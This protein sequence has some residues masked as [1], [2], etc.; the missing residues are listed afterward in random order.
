MFNTSLRKLKVSD[1]EPYVSNNN[2]RP[3]TANYY[4]DGPMV[5]GVDRT[6]DLVGNTTA[7]NFFAQ[8]DLIV[9]GIDAIEPGQ[10]TNIITL[11]GQIRAARAAL[12]LPR[13]MFAQ[14]VESGVWLHRQM[15]AIY[16]SGTT[17]IMWPDYGYHGVS[18]YNLGAS[19]NIAIRNSP[20]N[21]NGNY[22]VSGIG[23][24]RGTVANT[25]A[26]TGLTAAVPGDFA[27]VTG[28]NI[29]VLIDTPY[30]TAGNWVDSSRPQGESFAVTKFPA[31]TQTNEGVT[32]NSGFGTK[33]RA[34]NT[35]ERFFKFWEQVAEIDAYTTSATAGGKSIRRNQYLDHSP[36]SHAVRPHKTHPTSG[37]TL[38][39]ALGKVCREQLCHGEFYNAGHLDA[40]FFDDFEVGLRA[41]YSVE[42]LTTTG[43]D[44][45]G[46]G[47]NV[48]VTNA[49][50][51]QLWGEGIR[52][53]VQDF[54]SYFPG[55]KTLCNTANSY[56]LYG[57]LHE[58]NISMPRCKGVPDML[59]LEG[60]NFTTY[61]HGVGPSN[62]Y[63][64]AQWTKWNPTMAKLNDYRSSS[65][66]PAWTHVSTQVNVVTTAD[67]TPDRR[68]PTVKN[69]QQHETNKF[70]IVQSL[71]LGSRADQIGVHWWEGGNRTFLSGDVRIVIDEMKVILGE[72]I[73][74]PQ[75]TPRGSPHD[76]WIFYREFTNAVA[77]LNCHPGGREHAVTPTV[78]NNAT[79]LAL[80]VP[81]GFQNAGVTI[82]GSDNVWS[83]KRTDT[84]TWWTNYYGWENTGISSSYAIADFGNQVARPTANAFRRITS[85][86]G[87]GVN[88]GATIGAGGITL[89]PMRAVILLRI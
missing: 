81:P 4:Y 75:S 42:D 36:Y 44:F 56:T 71:M 7:I 3:R 46:T 10:I 83:V 82:H 84:G 51:N 35:G 2:F 54:V 20:G 1:L 58:R 22:T 18:S 8:H 65:S 31:T 27:R 45:L 19:A 14:Y 88:N 9:W 16:R 77:I 41:D 15:R 76:P 64:A 62:G 85:T 23:T 86:H 49:R 24:D 26:L 52:R 43:A 40:I 47:S 67:L 57:G 25:G 61:G 55:V 32:T 38:G 78:A 21:W 72:P 33:A 66:L 74:G 34:C 13:Q 60:E 37:L 89:A 53:F 73:D 39:A 68:Y 70:G 59:L 80:T 29:W 63:M 5:F 17:G 28:G 12:G 87:D 50:G 6:Y 30:S 48:T 79:M 69:N 11:F